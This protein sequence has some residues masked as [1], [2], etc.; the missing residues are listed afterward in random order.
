MRVLISG[1]GIAGNALAFWL[2]RQGHSVTVVERFPSLRASGLQVDLRGHGVEVL[3]RMGL[4]AAFLAKKAPEQGIEV[5][6]KH[7]RRR[8]FFPSN[9][10][11]QLAEPGKPRVQ[12][13]TSD[14]EI[15][16]GD[17]CQ[18][19]FG[20]AKKAN[21]TFVFGKSIRGFTDGDDSVEVNFS[22][23]TTYRY[24]LLVGADGQRSATRR[25]LFG[26]AIED[27][28]YHPFQDTYMAYFTIPRPIKPGEGYVG[29]IFIATN[30]RGIMTRRHAEDELQ[31]YIGCNSRDGRLE[32]ARR[33][34]DVP[35]Q[36]KIWAEIFDGAGWKTEEVMQ[37][38]RDT[39]SDIYVETPAL[40]KLDRWSKG[41]VALVGDA[42][43]CPTP[44]TGV[45]TTC[46]MIG[47]YVLA[48]EM[49]KHCRI[50]RGPEKGDL[51]MALKG[52]EDKFMPYMA[53][54]QRGVP[55]ENG[56]ESLTGRIIAT[57]FGISLF[58][59]AVSVAS[60]LNLNLGRWFLKEDV[61]KGWDLDEYRA[62]E[63]M[64]VASGEHGE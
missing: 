39:E 13:F 22:D 62:V 27:A 21:A 61:V 18:L 5:V 60:G 29:S 3:R 2:S 26:Q 34:G 43:W 64:D 10:L 55:V 56:G 42:A 49:A 4:E 51:A 16:R 11:S 53:E 57:S 19:L 12:N 17:L 52:F 35:E 6:D 46:A 1:A 23:G 50:D 30:R 54:I 45:G 28:C 59:L 32:E 37:A 48:G 9:N 44:T 24:D 20:A 14:Y 58:H 41:R 63:G 36:K 31:V 7:G 33:G 47:A 40:V 8:G 38:L 15:M 25:L